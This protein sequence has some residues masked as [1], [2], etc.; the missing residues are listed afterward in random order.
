MYKMY[1]KRKVKFVGKV[2]SETVYEE[3]K[4]KEFDSPTGSGSFFSGSLFLLDHLLFIKKKKKC[5]GSF[6]LEHIFRL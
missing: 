2:S 1:E 4:S 6:E 5:F 3:D